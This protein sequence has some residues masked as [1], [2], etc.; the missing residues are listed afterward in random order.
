MAFGM[1]YV[2]GFREMGAAYCS[3]SNSAVIAIYICVGALLEFSIGQSSAI[4]ATVQDF[5]TTIQQS[6]LFC[7]A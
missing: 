6:G 7:D 3:F 2:C 4:G 1:T 5:V